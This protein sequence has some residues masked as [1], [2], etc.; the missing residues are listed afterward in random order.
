MPAPAFLRNTPPRPRGFW[1]TPEIAHLFG[2]CRTTARRLVE[3]GEIAG[4]R[5]GSGKWAVTHEAL[6]AFLRSRPEFVQ[7]VPRAEEI[8][9]ADDLSMAASEAIMRADISPEKKLAWMYEVCRDWEARA[10]AEA[11]GSPAAQ[12]PLPETMVRSS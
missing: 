11:D 10:T 1:S 3:R 5:L 4:F 6:I 2:C 12:T 9:G 8:G 7:L